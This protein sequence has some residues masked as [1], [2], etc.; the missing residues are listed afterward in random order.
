MRADR[1]LMMFS[2]LHG[3]GLVAEFAVHGRTDPCILTR[4]LAV[5]NYAGFGILASRRMRCSVPPNVVRL[6][7][8]LLT[9]SVLLLRCVVWSNRRATGVQISRPVRACLLA[10]SGAACIARRVD[11]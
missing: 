1:S 11:L 4:I 5:G 10:R 9:A 8:G 2:P 6:A 3:D 7:L